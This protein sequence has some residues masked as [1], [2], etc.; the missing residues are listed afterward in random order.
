MLYRAKQRV[1]MDVFSDDLKTIGFLPGYL[2]EFA[3]P[4]PGTFTCSERDSEGA[5]HH[6]I[7]ALDPALLC[8]GIALF[9][10]DPAHKKHRKYNGIQIVPLYRWRTTN[11]VESEQTK[12]LRLKP[13]LLLPSKYFR[14]Y[15]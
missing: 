1:L 5:F 2:T 8:F 6:T 3:S 4:N 11:F 7:V 15:T 14:A 10:V 9:G 13:R 12:S